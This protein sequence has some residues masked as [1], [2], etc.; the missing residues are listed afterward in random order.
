MAL[1]HSSKKPSKISKTISLFYQSNPRTKHVPIF[2]M[3]NLVWRNHDALE[4]VFKTSLAVAQHTGEALSFLVLLPVFPWKA[5]EGVFY[6]M[7]KMYCE[8]NRGFLSGI[9]NKKLSKVVSIMMIRSSLLIKWFDKG[10]TTI[11]NYT[12]HKFSSC[13]RSRV[14]RTVQ[15]I[16][17]ILKHFPWN[18]Q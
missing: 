18:T 2:F 4:V 11:H 12:V 10:M 5:L 13:Q 14:F 1:D 17:S 3:Q 6:T 15:I 16:V 8:E 7:S 9:M